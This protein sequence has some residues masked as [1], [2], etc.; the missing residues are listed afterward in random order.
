MTQVYHADQ[1]YQFHRALCEFPN[2][3]DRPFCR[4]RFSSLFVYGAGAL[5]VSVLLAALAVILAAKL[6]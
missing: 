4:G 1:E 6:G 3:E 5:G 2:G